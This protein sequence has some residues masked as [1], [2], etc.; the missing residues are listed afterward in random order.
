VGVFFVPDPGDNSEGESPKLT[1]FLSAIKIY[2]KETF[3]LPGY[4]PI[5]IAD[6]SNMG[7][8]IYWC[9]R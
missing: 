6:W 9:S 1:Q 4:G 2:L 7:F 3:F 8:S 5:A